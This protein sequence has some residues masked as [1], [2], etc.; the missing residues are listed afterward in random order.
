[1]LDIGSGYGYFIDEAAKNGYN[2]VGI[3]PSKSLSATLIN[4]LI[5]VKLHNV[6]YEAYF[7]KVFQDKFKLFNLKS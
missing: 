1:M 2:V 5:K 3:E 7:E 6:D 4:H